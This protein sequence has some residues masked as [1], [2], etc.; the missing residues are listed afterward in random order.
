MECI[1]GLKFTEIYTE[2]KVHCSPVRRCDVVNILT[3]TTMIMDKVSFYMM[4]TVTK[5]PARPFHSVYKTITKVTSGLSFN[6]CQRTHKNIYM[7]LYICV[8]K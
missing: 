6:I 5:I 3:A 8:T 4:I 1:L 7:Y 2:I